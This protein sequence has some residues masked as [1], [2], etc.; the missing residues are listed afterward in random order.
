MVIQEPYITSLGLSL[1]S[2]KLVARDR[3]RFVENRE[4]V[5][6]FRIHQM[7]DLELRCSGTEL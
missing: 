6:I 7:V 4:G 1:I 5:D 3:V 2:V